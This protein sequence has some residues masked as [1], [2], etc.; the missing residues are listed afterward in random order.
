MNAHRF[1]P[2]SAALGVVATGAGAAVIVG[3]S[4]AIDSTASGVWIAAIALAIGVV[5]LPWGRRART[6]EDGRARDESDLV[7]LDT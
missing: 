2:V 3:A 4:D 6:A 1:D 5:L 7:D